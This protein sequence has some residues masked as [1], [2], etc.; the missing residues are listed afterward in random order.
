MNKTRYG[1]FEIYEEEL[2]DLSYQP[3]GLIDKLIFNLGRS[4]YK[5]QELQ[6]SFS[7]PASEYLRGE[8]FCNDV[9]EA[10]ESKFTQRDLISLLLDDFLYQAKQRSNPYDL[11]HELD[12]RSEHSLKVNRYEGGNKTYN[13]NTS[14]GKERIFECTIRRKEALRLEVMLSDIAELGENKSFTVNQVLRILYSDFIQKYR[15][16]NLTN[17]I[18]NIV[19]RYRNL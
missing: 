11:Y 3:S 15:T 16:G 9:S 19:A 14:K 8:L 1:Q 7:V 6:Y 4:L 2:D 10:M 18:E 12:I 17:V 13:R 5:S